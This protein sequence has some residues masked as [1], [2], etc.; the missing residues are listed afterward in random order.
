M[1]VFSDQILTV[2]RKGVT[3][4]R[5]KNFNFMSI[6]II[7][8]KPFKKMQKENKIRIIERKIMVSALK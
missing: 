8:N 3:T 2:K 1:K 6:N 4:R 5:K 7:I